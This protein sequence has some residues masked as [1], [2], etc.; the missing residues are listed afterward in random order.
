MQGSQVDSEVSKVVI[1][2][3]GVENDVLPWCIRYD[4]D[5]LRRCHNRGLKGGLAFLCLFRLGDP[6]SPHWP[7]TIFVTSPL[8]RVGTVFK[9]IEVVMR[10]GNLA[11]GLPAP[12][13]R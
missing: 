6:G 13:V 11:V 5:I 1:N 4:L 2:G 3:R 8:L 10:R 12:L 9:A 7:C